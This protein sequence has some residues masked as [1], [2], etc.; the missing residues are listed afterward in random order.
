VPGPVIEKFHAAGVKVFSMCGT[1]RHAVAAAAAGCDAVVAQGGEA[2][3]HT[4]RVAGL[5]LIPQVVDAVDV[6]VLG[7][8]SIVDGRGVAAALA[9]GAQGVW[10][11]T[12]FIA[13][14]EAR[15]GAAYKDS[16]VEAGSSDTLV[17]RC[18]SGKP[19]RVIKNDY[20]DGWTTREGELKPFPLQAVHS[21]ETG[22]M[23]FMLDAYDEMTS[24]SSC[25]PAGQG[26]GGIDDIVPAAEVVRRLVEDAKTALEQAARPF[27]L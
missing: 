12:R 2:G 4:G 5:A 17:T 16:I 3:G 20:A 11:G 10:I 21:F 8:G 24:E 27:E 23:N 18:Y 7:A 14:P 22:V 6:P 1:V 19:M 9:L 15:A 26:C 25:M 13:T